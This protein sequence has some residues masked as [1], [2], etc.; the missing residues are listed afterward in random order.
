M[1]K[2]TFTMQI[3]FCLALSPAFVYSS[4]LSSLAASM[5]PG[6]WAELSTNG[7]TRSL[8]STG[9]VDLVI[10]YANKGVWDAVK[11]EV[12]F[13]GKGHQESRKFIIYQES[14]NTWKTGP[15]QPNS[16]PQLKAR[17]NQAWGQ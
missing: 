5:A 1:F 12:R 4:S 13:A 6:T 10:N 11:K 15:T 16:A 3:L 9:S 2:S 7:Y 17:P 8:L 14:N